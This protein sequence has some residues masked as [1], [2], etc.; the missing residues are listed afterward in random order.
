MRF[1]KNILLI[2]AGMVVGSLV[3]SLTSGTKYFSWLSYGLV[4]G[5][6]Q[7]FSL[8]LGV[9]SLTLGASINITVSTI[10]FVTAVYLIGRKLL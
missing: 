2:C 4:F 9:L 6:E 1:W 3:S 10:I 5:T 7:P 8:D